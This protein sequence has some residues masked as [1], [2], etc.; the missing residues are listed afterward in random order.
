MRI[1]HLAAGA[2]GMYCGSCM[3]DNRLA[4]ALRARGRDVVLVPLYTP[5]RTDEPDV[6]ERRVFYGGVNV[7]LQQIAGVFRR[8]PRVLDRLLDA[9]VLLRAVGRFAARTRPEALGAMTLSVLRG[10]DGAQ[11]KELRKLSAGLAALRP[12]LVQLPN[13]MFAGVARRLKSELGVPVL[14]GLTGEDVFLD[15]LPELYRKEA[16][17][18]IRQRA[19]DVDGFVALTAYYARHATEHFGLPAQ[20]VHRI[21]M[22]IH[23]GDFGAPATPPET[24]FTIGYLARISPE[25]GLDELARAFAALRCNGRDCRLRVAGYL[26]AA[27]RPYLDG[28]RDAVRQAGADDRF[29]YVGEVTRE[30]KIAFLRSLH[31]LCVPT[32]YPESKGFYVLEA[33]AAGVPVVQPSHGS[34][35]E[36]IAATGG[37]LLY[38]A[39]NPRALA[40]GLS[41]LMDDGTL[42]RELAARGRAAV[43]ERFSAER[44]AD[45]AWQ[46]YTS[47]WPRC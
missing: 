7:Y 4:A 41:R 36:L 47:G 45:A 28:V 43:H 20:R 15:R 13:L 16:F 46:L 42:R 31:V 33:L 14:C 39:G 17:E 18:I 38:D 34:F 22:G 1:V 5:L 24:P 29:E 9:G 11:R 8:T 12:D 44:M 25:K 23:I 30:Q 3:H 35:P 37:G 21:P 40:D 26:G 27:D 10:E 6:S 19:V 32:W 2:A